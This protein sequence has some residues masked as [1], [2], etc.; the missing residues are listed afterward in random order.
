MITRISAKFEAP[1]LAELAIGRV[2]K[3]VKGVHSA[4]LAYNRISN[5]AEKLRSGSIYTLIPTVSTVHSYNYFTAVM[6]QPAS[7]DI[8]PEPSRSRSTSIYLICEQDCSDQ[9]C[10]IL[11][12]LGG[13]DVKCEK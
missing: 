13:F 8:I 5:H 11:H 6:E 4:R 12:A 2:K 9:A 3:S 10:S 7:E 1:E